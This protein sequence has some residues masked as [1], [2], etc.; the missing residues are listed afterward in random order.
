[1]NPAYKWKKCFRFEFSAGA[2]VGEN[3]L[4]DIFRCVVTDENN[5]EKKLHLIVKLP[6]A[7][8]QRR[9][10]IQY[11]R[12]F[13]RELF[14]YGKVLPALA[15]YLKNKYL[16]PKDALFPSTARCVSF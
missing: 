6:P 5:S 7:T 13:N 16:L 10:I 12:F 9:K 2:K 14:M 3:F 8:E 1:M 4:G 11:E 15:N